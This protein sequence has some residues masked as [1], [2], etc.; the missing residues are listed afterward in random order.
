MIDT[1]EAYRTH[2]RYD[3]LDKLARPAPRRAGVVVFAWQP[4]N[5]AALGVIG[6]WL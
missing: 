4:K 2:W 5:T 6:P 3:E 1:L